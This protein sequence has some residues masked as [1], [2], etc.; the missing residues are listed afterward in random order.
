MKSPSS[1][2]EVVLMW[3]QSWPVMK[4]V[5]PPLE[6][7]A[8]QHIF[9][10]GNLKVFNPAVDFTTVWD[11]LVK[12]PDERLN[13]PCAEII[14]FS[15][16]ELNIQHAGFLLCISEFYFSSAQV[17]THTSTE[18]GEIVSW[19]SSRLIFYCYGLE[20]FETWSW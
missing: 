1:L 16:E 2:L 15:L 12:A 11:Y 8:H 14:S 4:A 10:P 6:G 7:R 9:A 5:L 18:A 17:M 20:D 13:W 19:N 3:F